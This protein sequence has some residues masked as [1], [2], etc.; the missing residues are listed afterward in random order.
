ML[1]FRLRGQLET[2]S[3]IWQVIIYQTTWWKPTPKSSRKGA[4]SKKIY[5]HIFFYFK[6]CFN[7]LHKLAS[8]VL[9][10]SKQPENQKV[11]EW[12]QVSCWQKTCSFS[13]TFKLIDLTT[14]TV[15]N[16]W[17]HHLLF[18]HF[19]NWRYG[20]FSLG[21][22]ATQTTSPVYHVHES[23]GAIRTRYRVPQV[24]MRV[25]Q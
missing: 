14:S 10:S 5:V 1:S 21:G 12:I 18:L 22:S 4:S 6:K 16:Y 19:F 9:M 23:V 13:F 17:K 20:G 25:G 24:E 3:R 2:S 8:F 7:V 15:I 11:G